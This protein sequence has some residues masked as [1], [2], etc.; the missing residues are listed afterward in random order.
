M[1]ARSW[2]GRDG[3]GRGLPVHAGESRGAAVPIRQRLI[4]DL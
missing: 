1:D 3:W 4:K 2:V